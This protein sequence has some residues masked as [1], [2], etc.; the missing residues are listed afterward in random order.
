[1]KFSRLE[2]IVRLANSLLFSLLYGAEFLPQLETVRQCELAWWSGVRSFYGLPSGVSSVFLSL[3]FPS[4]SLVHRVTEARVRLPI[5]ASRGVD[6]L[7]SEAVVC[8]RA[9]LFQRGRR[10]FSQTTKEWLEQLGLSLLVY[11]SDTSVIRAAHLLGR[12]RSMDEAWTRFAGMRST[13]FAAGILGSRSALYQI[14][15]EASKFSR[16]GVRAVVLS[17]SGSLGLSYQRSRVCLD[18]GVPWSFEHFLN[19]PSLG[20]PVQHLL[21]A[22]V[23]A[24]SWE[25]ASLL[26]LGRFEVFL[27]YVKQGQFTAEETEL[28][29]AISELFGSRDAP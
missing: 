7:F 27:H 15:R 19:C 10:G 6:T 20:S 29:S 21:E 28:F 1:L 23:A 18:C 5:R 24:K 25:D 26:L 11:E 4:F 17:M 2:V 22:H 16:L 3:L 12:E 9:V 8:D 13:S 14:V